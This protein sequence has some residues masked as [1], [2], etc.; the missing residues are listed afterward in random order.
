MIP[1]KTGSFRETPGT[2]E[3]NERFLLWRWKKHIH[4]AGEG[5]LRL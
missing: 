3:E 5:D 4:V 1:G 2:D